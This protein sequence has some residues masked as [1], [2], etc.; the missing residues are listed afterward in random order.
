MTDQAEIEE[1]GKEE[2]NG[3]AAAPCAPAPCA[4]APD[5][6]EDPFTA[7][8][9]YAGEASEDALI[10]D[11]NGYE[12]PLDLLLDMARTQKVDITQISIL[13]LVEQYLVFIAELR[14]KR[15][16]LAADYL[17]MAAWLAYL[18]SRLLLPDLEDDS[19]EPSGEELAAALAFRLRR[20][21]AMRDVASQ[22]MNRNRLGRDVFA[23]G[24]PEGVRIERTSEYVGDLY[25]LLRAYAFQRES[26]I[27]VHY[28]IKRLPVLT[29]NRAREILK[30]LVGNI[31]EWTPMDVL[32]SHYT[33]SEI[34]HGSTVASTFGASLEL[35]REGIIELRQSSAFAPLY[36]RA[37]NQTKLSGPKSSGPKSSGQ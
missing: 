26:Q 5:T 15:L 1:P 10:I 29:L 33:R 11:V 28:I 25:D 8:T 30:R 21:E 19:E 20:L 36:M 27:E 22:L 35:A 37:G 3:Q 16:E 12:G 17:V 6:R 9:V 14:Q 7:G 18:K 13:A 34:S 31:A 24:Q 23:R 2:A 4:P 32:L